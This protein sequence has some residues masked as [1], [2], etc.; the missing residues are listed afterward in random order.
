MR[1]DHA[2]RLRSFELR[3]IGEEEVLDPVARV[4][5]G[6]LAQSPFE[7]VQCLLDG[8]IADAVDRDL[9]PM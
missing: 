9:Q 8:T 4:L 6:N 2:Q 5:A 1:D 3:N 7:R